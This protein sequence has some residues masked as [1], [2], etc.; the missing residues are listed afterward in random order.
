MEYIVANLKSNKDLNSITQYVNDL[1]R[2]GKISSK[3]IICPPAPYLYLFDNDNYLL[4]AQDVSSYN[5]G[6]YTGE[7]NANIYKCLNAKYTIVGHSERRILF[8]E[9]NA[10]LIKKITNAFTSGLEVIY[11]IGE[12][13]KEN[14]NNETDKVLEN[15]I[16]TVLNEFNREQLKNII[17]A[18]EPVWSIG[19]GESP[20]ILEIENKISF[21]K[22]IIRDYY[23]LQLPVL[24]GGSISLENISMVEKIANIDGIVI[25]NSSLDANDLMQ[26]IRQVSD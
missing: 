8:N 5:E 12:T 25:G 19:T 7:I 2:L 20:S 26:I 16:A 3:L 4:G 21:I 24:Y 11:C 10:I 22:N 14:E 9:T 1:K 23:E 15:Q 6:S 17:I 18:Y 13:K